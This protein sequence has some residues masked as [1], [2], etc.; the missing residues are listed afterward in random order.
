M[1]GPKPT[2]ESFLQYLISSKRL[3]AP[4]ASALGRDAIDAYPEA[5]AALA[6]EKGLLSE[7]SAT[8]A[9]AAFYGYP[10]IDLDTTIIA[11]SALGKLS[12]ETAT[13]LEVFPFLLNGNELSVTMPSPDM[14]KCD[15]VRSATGCDLHVHLSTRAQILA[16]IDLHYA[17]PLIADSGRMADLV[18]HLSKGE[19]V[20]IAREVADSLVK[21]ALRLRA[22]DIHVEPQENGVRVRL[23]I[24]GVL[25][26]EVRLPSELGVVL[27]ARF[28]VMAEL[29]VAE[30]R[31]PQDG[32]I[33]VRTETR[34]LDLRISFAPT[35]YGEKIVIR[36][37]DRSGATT[38]LMAMELSRAVSARLRAIAAAPSG[39]LLVTG[40][41]GS[42]KS[43]TCYA[44]LEYLNR[45][46]TNIVTIEDPVEY[47]LEGLTQ[48]QVRH[49]IGL[50]F[51]TILRSVLRQDPDVIL[52]GEI[53]DTETARIAVQAALTG[54][55]VISTLHTNNALQAV[56]RLTE[57][58]V[59]P[60]LVA[61][62]LNGVLG[63][64]LAR[65]VC[66]RCKEAYEPI[67]EE[68]RLF[69][70]YGVKPETLF[71]GA[72]C[73]DCMG[74]GFHGRLALHEL[75]VVNNALRQLLLDGASINAIEAVARADGYRSMR[76]DGLKKALVGLTT[77][78][79]V[80]RVTVSGEDF[81]MGS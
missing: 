69:A 64:R 36:L 78:M 3:R 4:E 72:G 9:L 66:H 52:V 23:R 58:G 75:V 54:H 43:T 12:P 71:R 5:V 1:S 45:P 8:Q 27:A 17:T 16:A 49:G 22:S 18:A 35:S 51:S 40:P 19:D 39:I 46:E 31:I 32:R 53:R 70:P 59:E 47:R 10:F 28:K 65:R 38:D 13:E 48:I 14:D 24:D 29:D 63:Q 41:T 80:K 74:A 76:Y 42:G 60:F 20:S 81:A 7:P 50:D 68:V 67:A 57:M 15:R 55:L 21:N 77:A 2:R 33:A 62:S 79:E 44:V 37:L 25:R 26:E 11:P 61:P 73:A 56:L 34:A 30:S 6:V